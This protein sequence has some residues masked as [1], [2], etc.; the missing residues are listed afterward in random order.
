[1]QPTTASVEIDL[2]EAQ[3]AAEL[4]RGL[5]YKLRSEHDLGRYEYTARVRIAPGEIPH[6]HPVLTLNTMLRTEGSLLSAYLHEQMHWYVTWYSYARTDG[7]RSIRQALEKRYPTVP[8]AFPE[9]A[10]SA[11]SSYLHLIVNW[12]EIE[13]LSI[14]L[15]RAAA[16][17]LASKNFVYSG[18]Y[19]I[20]LSEWDWLFQLYN[21]HYLTPIRTAGEMTVQDLALA[22]RKDEAPVTS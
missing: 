17:E 22:A 10:H 14:F 12:L 3:K 8:I 18:I 7:W 4:V 20:V 6:S 11:A 13:A 9:G 15:G 19:R 2:S 1:M 5:L 16:V 21:A